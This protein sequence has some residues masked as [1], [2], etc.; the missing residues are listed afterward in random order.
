MLSAADRFY[1]TGGSKFGEGEYDAYEYNI[2]DWDQRRQYLAVGQRPKGELDSEDLDEIQDRIAQAVGKALGSLKPSDSVVEVGLEYDAGP[3]SDQ[4]GPDNRIAPFYPKLTDCPSLAGARTIR[5]DQLVEADRMSSLVD[6]CYFMTLKS[7]KNW[8]AFK[9]YCMHAN[10]DMIWQE[11]HLW[12]GLPKHPLIAEFDRVV[13]DEVESRVVGFTAAYVSGGTIQHNPPRLFKFKWLE[14][15]IEVVDDLNLKYGIL[16]R[17]IHPRNI[18]IESESDSIKI[19]DFN[20]SEWIGEYR[21]HDIDRREDTVGAAFSLYEIITRDD[22]FRSD[23]FYYP[24]VATVMSMKTWEAHRDV[25]LDRPIED[26]RRRLADW[27]A[28]R[29]KK[30][31]KH[32]TECLEHIPKPPETPKS[33]KQSR[34]RKLVEDDN[35][36]DQLTTRE[37]VQSENGSHLVK[38][39]RPEASKL[40]KGVVYLANGQ[41]LQGELEP[42]DYPAVDSPVK[43]NGSA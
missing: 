32:F 26:F 4:S 25:K 38:W 28:E 13:I 2:I 16:H 40:V 12:K 43:Q 1:C 17:D 33:D 37:P 41:P 42:V 18:M 20:F 6:I 39:D 8:R 23:T 10:K 35:S 9:Y 21:G 24:D 22:S 31:V 3:C 30:P 29:S 7:S 11:L 15:L 36:V 5:R 34:K 14:Q 19:I 27:L